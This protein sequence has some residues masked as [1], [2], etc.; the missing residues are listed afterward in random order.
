MPQSCLK[1]SKTP[2]YSYYCNFWSVVVSFSIANSTD[3]PD[4]MRLTIFLVVPKCG[5]YYALICENR[6]VVTNSQQAQKLLCG[7]CI[8]LDSHQTSHP[9][10]PLTHFIVAADARKH[11]TTH[12]D[13]S[14]V[15]QCRFLCLSSSCP[16]PTPP[17]RLDNVGAA[18]DRDS[19]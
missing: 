4:S 9:P 8:C 1:T 11:R 15:E 13:G 18:D 19:A 14:S 12:F 16:K 10:R 7:K 6:Y 3:S 5:E 17:Q 2:I